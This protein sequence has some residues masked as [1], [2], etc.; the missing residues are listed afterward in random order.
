[1][2]RLLTAEQPKDKL[3]HAGIYG[4]DPLYSYFGKSLWS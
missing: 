4:V 1:M 3:T 2:F